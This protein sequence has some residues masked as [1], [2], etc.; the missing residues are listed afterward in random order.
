MGI[1]RELIYILLI[2]ASLFGQQVIDRI[3]IH[4]NKH[5]STWKIEQL[6]RTE[7]P[8]F[9]QKII[10]KKQYFKSTQLE[11]DLSIIQDYYINQG[12]IDV[13]VKATAT[14][15]PA[16]EEELLINVF[17][18]EGPRYIVDEINL[19]GDIPPGISEGELLNEIQQKEGAPLQPRTIK[20]DARS[21]RN[22]LRNNGYPYAEATG[23]YETI[24]DSLAAVTMTIESGKIGYFGGITYLGLENTKHS[25]VRKEIEFSRGELYDASKV[26][27]TRSAL[28]RTGLFSIVGIEPMNFEQKPETLDYKITVAEK[29]PRW[30]I[31]RLGAGSDEKYPI[32]V[33]GGLGWGH[34]NLF[35]TGRRFTIEATSKWEVIIQ[36]SEK[37]WPTTA[38]H[39]MTNRFDVTYR[40][41][42]I[43]GTRTPVTLNL[44]FEPLNREEIE[45]YKLRTVGFQI[46]AQHEAG[47][48]WTH[49]LS[50]N[51]ERAD[52]YDIE[53]PELQEEILQRREQPI[54]R[55]IGYSA[56]RDTR[57][58][59]LVPTGGTYFL[60]QLEMG[61][62]FLGGDENYTKVSLLNHRYWSFFNRYIFA[63][64][65]RVSIIGNWK[66]GEE[67]ILEHRK[68]FLGGAN[69]I[70][71]W[72]ERSIGPKYSDG[73]P[74]GGKTLVLA[75]AEIRAPIVWN[76]W[77]HAFFDIGNLWAYAEAFNPGE[78][79]GSAG[80][81]LAFITP[82][83][84]IRFDYGY[85]IINKEEPVDG[86]EVT[87]S[88]WHL[89][90]MYAF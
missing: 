65:G 80:W 57:D 16:A 26:T 56:V 5:I 54:S 59:I 3:A 11:D 88:T 81:G 78:L 29:P 69:T 35:G 64:R 61:G 66:E 75:N 90:L 2:A 45:Q 71:G 28:Y 18:T 76:F 14:P 9:F 36:S 31:T 60:G 34:R 7:P 50:F 22:L 55:R 52:I 42:W 74:R 12:Y 24:G 4:G 89:S 32:F 20:L 67:D 85:Q 87:N 51:Y 68:F 40:E 62:Y 27:E 13:K 86:E 25:F 44:Y 58:N 17:I 83:G 70:R 82:I 30:I 19:K 15:Q 38:I 8:S 63:L 48:D 1:L 37:F 21:V 41:P 6:M 43:L 10:G 47:E 77:G 23:K 33:R 79:K 53:N 84:P 49:T 46:N 72:E 39:N 73:Q